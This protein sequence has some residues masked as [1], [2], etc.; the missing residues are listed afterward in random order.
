MLIDLQMATDIPKCS[1]SADHQ[2]PFLLL[3]E[4]HCSLASAGDCQSSWQRR[5]KH[6]DR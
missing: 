2:P 1:I 5:L 3:Q 4:G 6:D